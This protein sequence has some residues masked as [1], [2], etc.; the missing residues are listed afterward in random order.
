M[1]VRR[2]RGGVPESRSAGLSSWPNGWG[3]TDPA[4]IPPPGLF[5]MQRAGVPVT[6]HTSMQVDSVF[7]ALRVI[8]NSIIKMGNPMAYQLGQ[9]KLNR[10]YRE[11]VPN[12]P[13]ILT[14]TFGPMWQFD[15]MTRT[16]VSMALFGEAFWLTL[17]RDYLGFPS[18]LEVLHP[19]FMEVKVDDRGNTIF[20]YGAGVK[21]KQLDPADITHIPF[22]AM[23]GARRGLS[24][25]EYAGVAY[26]LALASMEYGQRWF[27]QGASP[28]YILSTDAK[29]GQEEVERIAQKFLIQHSGL[30]SAHL[31]LVV[32]NGLKVTQT[33][34]TPDQAQFLQTLEYARM[35]IGAWFGL[36]P[37]LIGA[38]QDRPNIWGM[39]VQE[40][41]FQLVDFTLSGYTVRLNEAFSS[42]LPRGT[43]AA[44]D[45]SVILRAKSLDQAAR[46]T[47]L[48][49]NMV[50]TQNE[51]RVTEL[52]L[53][54]LPGGDT[55]E[56]P[57]AS[58]VSG[59][60]DSVTDTAAATSAADES[61]T[62]GNN[63]TN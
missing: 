45:E 40:M 14:N 6:A 34:S 43:F 37:H 25:I 13:R 55:L 26:A 47:A 2:I 36:P 18:A 1:T 11:W 33:Q 7:T 16:V 28:G 29:L 49:S 60:S 48:R 31:P 8:S 50:A 61:A 21:K 35:A 58:N 56:A 53:P 39:T 62:A 38:T 63:N 24:S 46:I 4:A 57:L 5:Q 54:P 22:V 3:F 32:D 30:Q 15:G 19:A 59:D 52:N 42:L 27:S 41:G 9:D 20:L 51:V 17:T 23:P 10:Q 44:L 12:Q